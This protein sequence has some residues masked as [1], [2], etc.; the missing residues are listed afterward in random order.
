MRKYLRS[1]TRT[2]ISNNFLFQLKISSYLFHMLLN[3]N[4]LFK[5]LTMTRY[6]F[7]LLLTHNFL[8]D[9]C[10]I[11]HIYIDSML[12][13]KHRFENKYLFSAY[14]KNY[15]GQYLCV[16]IWVY[17]FFERNVLNVLS[18]YVCLFTFG[19]N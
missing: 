2:V 1:K 15:I 7:F 5:T 12:K 14:K 18:R 13:T 9:T 19:S 16:N 6:L 10:N 17:F 8:K 4:I 11:K 3:T